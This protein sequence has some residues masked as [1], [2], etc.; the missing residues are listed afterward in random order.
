MFSEISYL[1]GTVLFPAII[2]VLIIIIPFALPIFLIVIW[3]TIRLYNLQIKYIQKIDPV[4]LEIK[5]PKE[6][7]KSPAA[8]EIF[9][10]AMSQGG[11]STFWDAFFVG[12]VKPWF[13]CELVSME[14]DVKFFVWTWKK[15]KNLIETQLYAQFPSLEIFEVEDYA[16]GLTYSKD[17]QFL[18]GFQ[19]KLAKADPYPIKTYV[20]FGL[21]K[22]D[23][24]EYKVDPINTVLEFLGTMKKGENAFM[25]ILIQRH[26]SEGW[27]DGRLFKKPDWKQAIKDE[28][29]SLRDK[30]IIKVE[31]EDKANFRMP[32]PTKGEMEVINAI[33]RSAAKQPFDCIIR[34]IYFAENA[35]MNGYNINGFKAVLKPFGTSNLNGFKTGAITSKSDLQDDLVA[36]LPWLYKSLI[37]SEVEEDK[38]KIFQAYKQRSFFQVPF[39]SWGAKG[40]F[41]L[42]TEELATLFHFPSSTVSQ[43]PTLTRVPSKKSEA[44]SNLPI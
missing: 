13:S 19:Y 26:E 2:K 32:N 12:E 41:V 27:F 10:M 31:G 28:I 43:T 4:L 36:F 11:P 34:C 17:K 42:N 39:R 9:F 44:P 23:K 21:D 5:L 40:P 33:E 37:N 16:K 20:D 7:F 30:T 1:L 35:H 15:Y 14:G 22:N 25:Q 8:M 38:N 18:F 29:K 24:D 6:L 3:W